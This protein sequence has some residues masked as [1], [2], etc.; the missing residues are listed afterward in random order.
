[1]VGNVSSL[2]PAKMARNEQKCFATRAAWAWQIGVR[3]SVKAL[4]VVFVLGGCVSKKTIIAHL[5][6][7]MVK[8]CFTAFIPCNCALP[9]DGAALDVA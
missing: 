9:T 3:E 2:K 5:M 7:V 8:A 6:K 1:M 4:F